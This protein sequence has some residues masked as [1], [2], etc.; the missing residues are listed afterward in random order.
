MQNN[1]NSQEIRSLKIPLPTL[2]VQREMMR[3][4]EQAIRTANSLKAEAKEILRKATTNVEQM[5]LGNQPVEV[6]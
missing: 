5:I 3:N 1:I 4:V 6:Y 2:N